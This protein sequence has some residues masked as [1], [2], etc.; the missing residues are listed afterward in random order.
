MRE[1]PRLPPRQR[2]YDEAFRIGIERLRQRSAED[3]AR[4]GARYEEGIIRLPVLNVEFHVNPQAAEILLADGAAVGVWWSVLSVH[5]LLAEPSGR[6]DD[7]LVGFPD[8]TEA[9]TYNDPYKGRALRRL[10]ATVGRERESL[11][12]AALALGGEPADFGDA[13]YRFQV[14]PLVPVWLVW[15]E[16]DDEF[17]PACTLLYKENILDYM[18]VEDVVVTAERLAGRLGGKP[19]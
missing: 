15:H 14:F 2:P 8:L 7:R 12:R 6:P 4:L 5:Y 1:P 13:S 19:W 9:R 16:G 10:E 11:E 18:S 17:P 3:V